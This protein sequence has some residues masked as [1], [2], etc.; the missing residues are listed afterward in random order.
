LHRLS[1]KT[2]DL[3]VNFAREFLQE[4]LY[5]ERNVGCSLAGGSSRWII[6][7]IG[8]VLAKVARVNGSL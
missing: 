4:V 6:D 5:E 1:R 7:A 2:V 3:F 8:K